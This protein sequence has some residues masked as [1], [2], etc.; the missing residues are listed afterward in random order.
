MARDAVEVSSGLGKGIPTGTVAMLGV[1]AAA[2][3][4]ES[5]MAGRS[6]SYFGHHDSVVEASLF[7]QSEAKCKHVIYRG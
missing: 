5:F 4:A 6:R 3:D 1:P 2:E 7:K